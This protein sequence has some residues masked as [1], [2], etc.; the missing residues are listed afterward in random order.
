MKPLLLTMFICI[1][2]AGMAQDSLLTYSKV[3]SIDSMNK[4]DIYNKTLLWCSK[5]FNDAK[6]AIMVQNPETGNI[7]GK[8]Y[9]LSIY[10]TPKKKGDSVINYLGYT[11]FYFNWLIEIKDQKLRFSISEIEIE[12]SDKKYVATN[13][14]P[15]IKFSLMSK[16]KNIIDWE[17]GKLY[18][19]KHMNEITEDLQTEIK[20]KPADF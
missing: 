3:I 13:S 6:S 2:A 14:T 18:F 11:D 5:R 10:K 9:Y 20:T 4:T 17:C 12:F 8:A 1:S 16:E 7:A 19:I 15:P